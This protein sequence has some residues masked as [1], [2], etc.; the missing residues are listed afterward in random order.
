MLEIGFSLGILSFLSYNSKFSL[1]SSFVL[2]MSWE[3]IFETGKY[4]FIP[5][6]VII[7]ISGR[8]INLYFFIAFLLSRFRT[9]SSKMISITVPA[10]DFLTIFAFLCVYIPLMTFISCFLSYPLTVLL[11]TTPTPEAGISFQ[12][13]TEVL[14]QFVARSHIAQ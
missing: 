12:T 1:S 11:N 9:I 13:P 10:I 14:L 8:Y 6:I 2:K 5:I 3:T 7:V 4:Y